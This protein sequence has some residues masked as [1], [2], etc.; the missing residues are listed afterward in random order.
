MALGC[1]VS[2]DRPWLLYSAYGNVKGN[3]ILVENLR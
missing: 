3:L 1:S 2:P